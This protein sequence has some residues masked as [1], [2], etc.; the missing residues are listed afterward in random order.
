MLGFAFTKLTI[1]R[2]DQSGV[3]RFPHMGLY[4]SAIDE[5]DDFP[6]PLQRINPYAGCAFAILDYPH[7]GIRESC[8]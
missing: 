5:E 4:G 2:G 6:A 7:N 8:V 3:N 1:A